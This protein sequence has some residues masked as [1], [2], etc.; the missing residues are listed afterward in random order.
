MCRLLGYL[1]TPIL[2]E[3]LL[4]QPDHSLIVQSYQ[5]REMTSGVVNADGFGVGWYHADR[6]TAPF[7]Y[8]TILPVWNDVN[9]PSLSR[10][11]ESG[12]VLATVRSATAGQPVDLVNCQPFQTGNL[13]V[14]HNGFV[15]NFRETLYRPLRERMSDEAYQSIQGTTD[16]EH[17]FALLMDQVLVAR[18]LVDAVRQTLETLVE[19][20]DKYQTE[21]AANLIVSDGQQLVASRFANRDPVPTLYWLEPSA[22]YPNSILITSEPLLEG[23]WQAFSDRSLLTVTA[24]LQTRLI[25]L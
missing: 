8:K 11:I 10:Y 13:T 14:I 16:S 15:H 19:L 1:G 4:Y 17:I 3:K 21:F 6:S 22:A 20:A 2:L 7:S 23:A 12:C 5:P 18:S 24:D 25:A 9:L